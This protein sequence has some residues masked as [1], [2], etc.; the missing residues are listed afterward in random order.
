MVVPWVVAG[1][2]LVHVALAFLLPVRLAYYSTLCIVIA[3]AAAIFGC[4][5]AARR[6]GGSSGT[7]WWLMSVSVMLNSVADVMD[8][9][10]QVM[11]VVE[12]NPAPGVEVLLSTF[13]CVPLLLAVSM[14]F[15]M[16]ALRAIRAINAVVA[17]ATATLF[18][19][20]VFS[21]LTVH[22][23][24]RPADLLF[25]TSMFDGLDVFLAAA[26]TV[27]ALG[28]DEREEQFFFYAASIFLW[29]N[30]VLTSVHNRILIRHDYAWLDLLVSGPYL[31]LVA[32]SYREASKSVR[33]PQPSQWMMRI[34]RSGSP[35]FMSLNLLMLGILVSRLHF[36]IGAAGV[37][38][39]ILSYGVLNVLTQ[40]KRLEAEETLLAS[41]RLL[42]GL[43]G[44]DGLTG[45]AN[46][47]TF[48]Q[49]IDME[50]RA[51]FRSALP[52]SLLMVD[53]DLFKELNDAKGHLVG[54]RYLVKLAQALQETMPR[55]T[56]LVARYGGEEFVVLLPATG[57]F[58]AA[59]VAKRL[60]ETVSSLRLEHPRSVSGR[61]TVSIGFATSDGLTQISSMEL[62][63]AADR[64]LYRAKGMGRNR[65]EYC[66]LDGEAM[67]VGTE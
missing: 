15:D 32:M 8:F 19:V 38:L 9:R 67:M 30:A 42:E 31:V 6:V 4:V 20:L 37:V 61:T 52:V 64:A 24:D 60:H 34:V 36:Y 21:V 35:I 11:K 45:I 44:I 41:K 54:D 28:A 66:A 14:Q 33:R 26:A 7:L 49:K 12:S 48:D 58:G 27:R 10:A 25:I 22:G 62:I 5:Q 65:T 40:S 16:R 53:V 29:A 2:F 56:D 57:S 59:T 47:R 63:R 18:S 13:F 50:C 1:F 17:V 3:E 46:R 51:A 23:S 43:V 55:A 39:A